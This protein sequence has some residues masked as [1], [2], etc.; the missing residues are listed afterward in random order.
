MVQ[1]HIVAHNVAAW[2]AYKPLSAFVVRVAERRE[3]VIFTILITGGVIYKKFM[4]ELAKLTISRLEAIRSRINVIDLNGQDVNPLIPLAEFAPAFEALYSSKPLICKT[5]NLIIHGLPPPT[6]ALID[7]FAGYAVDAIQAIAGSKCS[8]FSWMTAPAGAT[9]RLFGPEKYGGV[10]DLSPK[11]EAEMDLSGKRY[12]EV[13]KEIYDGFSSGEIVRIPGIP[14]MYDYEWTPQEVNLS[15]QTFFITAQKYMR[16]TDGTFCVSSSIY[17]PEAMNAAK[18]WLNSIGKAWYSV[19]PLSLSES[20]PI[21]QA[22]DEKELQVIS[23]LDR[24]QS[25]F[26]ARSVFFISFGTIFWPAQPEKLWAI[27]DELIALRKPFILAHTSP[28]AQ[29]SDEKKKLILDSGI[30]MEMAWSPQ[31]KILSHPATGWFVTH[32]GWNSTQEAL[33]HRVPVIY[34]PFA[35]DQPY[36]AARTVQHNAGFE[37]IEVRTGK[38]GTRVP[39]RFKDNSSSEYP[40]FSISAAREEFKAVLRCIEGEEGRTIRANFERLGEMMDKTWD[41][42]HE[43]EESLGAFLRDF[44]DGNVA[45]S[46][47]SKAFA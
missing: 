32:G 25:A 7:P 20:M 23:F 44:V 40:T 6:V 42:G 34:W 39:Y 15:D 11:A 22:H 12:A 4:R 3:D 16:M 24:M 14:A 21:T 2:G 28:L 8:I 36:N 27:I 47:G 1:K 30:G 35:G 9:L 26:G 29:I 18:E 41:Q 46:I 31:E 33:A 45:H 43:A 5:T 37:L 10:G 17:E 13:A 38:L 19:G